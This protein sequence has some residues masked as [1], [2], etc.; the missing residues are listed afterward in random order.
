MLLGHRGDPYY[1]PGMCMCNVCVLYDV[2][3]LIYVVLFFCVLC[4]DECVMDECD[5]M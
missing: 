5:V 4:Y 2:C 3:V 1:V